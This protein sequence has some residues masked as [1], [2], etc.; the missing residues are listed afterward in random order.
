MRT[1]IGLHLLMILATLACAGPAATARP[2]AV[3]A[4]SPGAYEGWSEV[5]HQPARSI[6][7]LR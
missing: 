5:R 7:H 6:R 2:R 3:M 1:V 4:E